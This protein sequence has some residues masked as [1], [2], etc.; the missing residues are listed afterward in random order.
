MLT[1]DRPC[2][3]SP[4]CWTW[5]APENGSSFARTDRGREAMRFRSRSPRLPLRPEA[6]PGFKTTWRVAGMS[7]GT[8]TTFVCAG[9]SERI[10]RGVLKMMRDVFIIGVGQTPVGEHWDLGLRELGRSAIED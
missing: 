3:G 8:A 9:R 5:C 10:E 7:G 1:P 2:S 4:R 6:V